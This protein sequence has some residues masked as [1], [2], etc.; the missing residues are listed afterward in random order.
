MQATAACERLEDE[1][2]IKV[3]PE[4]VETALLEYRNSNTGSNQDLDRQVQFLFQRFLTADLR[5]IGAGSLPANLKV[6]GGVEGQRLFSTCCRRCALSCDSI[7]GLA[8]PQVGRAFRAAVRRDLQRRQT[9]T[10]TVRPLG[11]LRLTSKASLHS[12]QR[13]PR[14]LPELHSLCSYGTGGK[15]LLKLRLTDGEFRRV[16]MP[17]HE[18]CIALKIEPHTAYKKD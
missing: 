18:S 16:L 5:K 4:W 11:S 15:R 3:K 14:Q 9:S 6:F 13:A 12:L 17:S 7:A 1:F 2:S 10:E 8:R